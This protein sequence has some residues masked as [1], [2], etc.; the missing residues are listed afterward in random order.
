M[1]NPQKLHPISYLTGVIEAIKQNIFLIIIFL[2]FNIQDFDF[3]NITS[4]IFPAIVFAFFLFSFV[5]QVLKVYNTTYWIEN[6]HFVLATGIFT[7]ER[8]ELNIRRIQTLDTSQGIINQIVGGVKLQIK[9]P[10]DGIDLDT[11]SKKQGELIQLTIKEKQ[12]ELTSQNEEPDLTRIPEQED[13]DD[14]SEQQSQPV[15]LYKLNFKELLFMALTS[16]AIGVAFAAISP[17]IGA[18][19]EVIPWEW[20]TGEFARI[21][22]AIFVIVLI[23]VATIVVASYI[24]GTLIVII[25]NYNYT[26]TQNDNQLNIR[27]GLFNVKSITVPT[28]RVQ[29]VVEKQSFLRKLFGFTSIHFVITSDM[30]GNDKDDISLDGNVM[31]LPF[32]K[33]KKAFEIIKSLIPSMAFENAE[34]GMPWRGFH[35][36]FWQE[37]V[38]LL[39]IATIVNYFWSPW[40]FVIA[41]V[42]ILLLI[43]HSLIVIKSSGLKVRNDELVVRNVTTFGFKNTYF[44]HGKILGMEIKR[45]PFLINSDLGHFNF[46]IAKAAGN[47]A[48]GLKFNNYKEV[49]TL[50][51][52]YLRGEHHE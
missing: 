33:R 50:Q 48:V 19:S 13:N 6:D 49:E 43:I 10:S 16:G 30:N 24:L 17:I 44:K 23:M 18:F 26:V 34:Q 11:V 14:M 40:S 21:S 47:E 42:I 5:A 41:A 27:Y 35:R 51:N 37:T 2:V 25:K 4:Y 46:I 28:D 1:Y 52:W 32:I 45:N 29:A 22:Q 15:R 20:I 7:K 3:T 8:K 31:I 36:Y 38:I 12:Q 39:V 9:T